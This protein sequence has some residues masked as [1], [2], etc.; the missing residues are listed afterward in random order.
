MGVVVRAQ[1]EWDPEIN[2]WVISQANA[3]ATEKKNARFIRGLLQ[4]RNTTKTIYDR[5]GRPICKVKCSDFG[6]TEHEWEN[7]QDAIARPDAVEFKFNDMM[8]RL[9]SRKDGQRWL[10]RLAGRSS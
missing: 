6:N 5:Y 3:M 9:D 8:D 1:T 7:H 4:R 10:S 2:L